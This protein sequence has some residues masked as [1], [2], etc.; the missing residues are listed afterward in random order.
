MKSWVL[1]TA[2][3]RPS[4]K[5]QLGASEILP[6]AGCAF[7]SVREDD[8]PEAEQVAR[9][10]VARWVLRWWPPPVPPRD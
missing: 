6:N 7:I 10:L 3:A 8:K 5:A 1:A 2:S 9:D 4:P